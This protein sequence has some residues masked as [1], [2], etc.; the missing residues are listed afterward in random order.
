MLSLPKPG[1]AAALNL[2]LREAKS[3]LVARM[4]ADDWC[5]PERIERQVRA[6]S[7]MPRTIALGTAYEIE[8]AD[9]RIA[10]TVRP[11]RDPR[12]VR[13]RLLLANLF[14]HGSMLLRRDAVVAAGGY[15]EACDRAQDYDLWLRLSGR[16]DVC[17]VQ[18]VLYRYRTR[19]KSDPARSTARQ[20][21][22]AV[23][24]LLV[25]WRQLPAAPRTTGRCVRRWFGR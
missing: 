16:G 21:E 25:A 13:W 12:E 1:L 7:E 8:D 10:F 20:S 14:A 15:D 9:G 3:D 4:D 6:I 22:I 11:P 24:R 5:H 17:A 2:G 18:D 23:D 19:Q